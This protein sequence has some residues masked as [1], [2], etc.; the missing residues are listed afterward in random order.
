MG[1]ADND[2]YGV[3]VRVQDDNNFYRVSFH[4][5]AAAIGTTRPPRGMSVQKVRNG[6]WTELYRDDQAN[7]PF[8]PPFLAGVDPN[9]GLLHFLSEIAASDRAAKHNIIASTK[10]A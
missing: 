9:T 5:D 1:S 10:S 8:L 2:V 4:N 7:I 3:L 6:V